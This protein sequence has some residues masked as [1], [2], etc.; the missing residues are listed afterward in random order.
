M[1]IARTSRTT[2][3]QVKDD[4]QD[5]EANDNQLQNNSATTNQ[6][7]DASSCQQSINMVQHAMSSLSGV[8]DS[9]KFGEVLDKMFVPTVQAYR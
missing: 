8:R 3:R 1:N 4:K 2:D 9:K 5:A 7:K 6:S